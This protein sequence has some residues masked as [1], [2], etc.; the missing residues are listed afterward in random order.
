MPMP[1]EVVVLRTDDGGLLAVAKSL[2]DAEGIPCMESGEE[3]GTAVTGS[4]PIAGPTELR[5]PA[6]RAQEARELLAQHVE[7]P[8]GEE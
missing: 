8:E 6:D 1:D 4:N 2:L 3:L 5:V 7:L